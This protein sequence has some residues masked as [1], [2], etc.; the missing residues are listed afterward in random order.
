[1]T[2]VLGLVEEESVCEVRAME[3]GAAVQKLCVSVALTTAMG[4]RGA[5]RMHRSSPRL[6]YY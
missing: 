3:E 6:G 2:K 1:M 4:P 5:G